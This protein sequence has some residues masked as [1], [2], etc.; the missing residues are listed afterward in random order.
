M[1]V[2]LATETD[3]PAIVTLW[4]EMWDLHTRL[5]AHRFVAGGDADEQFSH[6]VHE[7]LVAPKIRTW[8]AEIEHRIVGYLMAMIVE[9][10]PVYADTLSGYISDVSVTKS[11]RSRGIGTKLVEAAHAWFRSFGVKH[12][13]LNVSAFNTEGRRFWKRAGYSDYLLR[14]RSEL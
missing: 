3:V 9:D 8:V 7:G 5:D 2:R 11:H 6:W 13:V 14:L 12:S 10:P 1:N 4:R